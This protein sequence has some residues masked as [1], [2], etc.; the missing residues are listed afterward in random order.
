MSEPI[1]LKNTKQFKSLQKKT[2]RN[3]VNVIDK[4]K[5]YKIFSNNPNFLQSEFIRL[6][7]IWTNNAYNSFHDH[8]KYLILIYLYDKVLENYKNR[9]IYFSFEDFYLAGELIIEKINLIEISKELSIPK[10]TVRRKINELQEKNIIF[11]KGSK[12]YLKNSPDHKQKPITSLKLIS[13]FLHQSSSLLQNEEWFLERP[14]LEHI[15]KFH[16]KYFTLCW[17]NFYNFQIPFLIRCRKLYGDLE[18]WNVWAS[19]AICQFL[20]YQNKINQSVVV[21][22]TDYEDMFLNFMEHKS[23]YGINASSISDISGIPRATVIRKLQNLLKLKL[24]KK[25][26]KLEFTLLFTVQNKEKIKKN[27]LINHEHL[28]IFVSNQFDLI[29]NSYLDL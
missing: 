10:E 8:D 25:N 7:Q 12:I 2:E 22:P 5:V 23:K 3:E 13:K 4:E 19:I 9:L 15:E 18:T 20:D 29:K 28:S 21:K 14:T 16:E 1:D 17:K 26:N 27:Y 6:Q 24:I 11:R